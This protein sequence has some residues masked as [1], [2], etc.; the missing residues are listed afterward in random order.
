MLRLRRLQRMLPAAAGATE[1]VTCAA[2][3][4]SIPTSQLSSVA[5]APRAGPS[6]FNRVGGGRLLPML[7]HQRFAMPSSNDLD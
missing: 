4:A 6:R 7:H 3:G 5:P 2:A 1:A